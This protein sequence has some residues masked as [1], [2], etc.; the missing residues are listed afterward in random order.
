MALRNTELLRAYVDMDERVRILGI[1]IKVWAKHCNI[2]DASR[3]SLSS[4]AYVILML[5]YLQRCQPPVVPFLQE[6]S[7]NDY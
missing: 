2:G 3:G 6:V 5:H 4:Y 7:I 1:L